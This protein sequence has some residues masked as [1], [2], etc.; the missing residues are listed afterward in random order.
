[1]PRVLAEATGIR[2]AAAPHEP[3]GSKILGIELLRFASAIAVL[4]FHYQH[5]AF[6]GTARADFTVSRQ[7]FYRFLSLFYI[8][9]FYGVEVFWC[10][11]GFIFFWKYGRSIAQARVGGHE[12]FIL[13]LSRLYPL[14]FVTLLFIAVMQFVYHMRNGAFFVYTYNDVHHFVLQLLLASNW[15]PQAV[16]SFNGP[17]W[18]ISVEVLVYAVFFLTL[19]YVSNSTIFVGAMA[20]AAAMIQ[21][22]KISS[23]P[24][25]ECLMFFYAGCL[26][27]IVYR[28]VNSQKAL[29]TAV[30]VGASLVIVILILL[31]AVFS[32]EVKAKTFLMLFTP[33]LIFLFV[34]HVPTSRLAARVL[35]PAGNITY[36]SYLMHFPI[37][38]LVVTL[39]GYAGTEIPIYTTGFFLSYLAVTL[40]ISHWVYVAFEMPAQ[41]MIRR[42][43][44]ARGGS[45]APRTRAQDP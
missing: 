43:F 12:F 44:L 10:I 35:V 25:F 5:F 34:A 17:I 1:V 36:A 7:P 27:A 40:F 18:S 19:R 3:E 26:T 8:D 23:Q 6:V 37:Q 22:F 45:V 41:R 14:H 32:V 4:L 9:G 31:V 39:F 21:I 2:G 15:V 24:I 11:S 13:R 29:K 38:I 20:L 30:S 33:A 28:R 16:E 42:R